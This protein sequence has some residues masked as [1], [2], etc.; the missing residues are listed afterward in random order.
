M[1]QIIASG[2]L[3]G[4]TGKT[5]IAV[6]LA[7]ALAT[8]GFE[9]W[10]LDVDPQGS[11]TEWAARGR[12]P[13]RV[14][15]VASIQV[16][17]GSRWLNRA[18]E[19]AKS[20]DLLVIDLPPLIVPAMASATMIAD[21]MLVPIT[22]SALEVA[23][24]ERVLRTIRI[25]RETRHA[26]RPKALLVPNKVD[27]QGHYNQATE[28]AVDSLHERWAPRVRQHTDHVNAFAV[29][30][31]VGRY[32]PGSPASQDIQALADATLAML[33]LQPPTRAE[34]AP[35]AAEAKLRA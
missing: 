23:P 34:P 31:W 5:T 15:S 18:A 16:T 10:V 21:L 27:L 4:G 22:P 3:K 8:R 2:N 6:N 26:D 17:G 30:E 7:C 33:G 32:A 1:G 35:P 14:E 28:A 25:T 20:V 11:A 24:T 19:L 9:V 13:V 29:G 12:L